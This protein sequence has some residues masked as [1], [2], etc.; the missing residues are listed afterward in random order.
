MTP[1]ALGIFMLSIQTILAAR[2][3]ALVL[4]KRQVLV[5]SGTGLQT[6]QNLYRSSVSSHPESPEICCHMTSTRLKDLKK[7]NDQ[8]EPELA[9][10]DVHK[11]QSS[12]GWE[13]TKILGRCRHFKLISAL[14]SHNQTFINSLI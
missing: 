9:C 10:Q 2:E 13:N 14:Y 11:Q 3:G 5:I 1:S 6:N 8:R 4:V 7:S 12:N